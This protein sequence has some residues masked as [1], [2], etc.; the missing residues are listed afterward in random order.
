MIKILL[1]FFFSEKN[2]KRKERRKEKKR[3]GKE[4]ERGRGK[5]TVGSLK[6]SENWGTLEEG[7]AGTWTEKRATRAIEHMAHVSTFL[8]TT[9]GRHL[10][11]CSCISLLLI[12]SLSLSLSDSRNTNSPNHRTHNVWEWD[13]I[14]RNPKAT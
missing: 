1:L 8:S 3:K 7:K 9:N 13:D 4:R 12:Q 11:F 6:G 14:T 5:I 10:F 2:E